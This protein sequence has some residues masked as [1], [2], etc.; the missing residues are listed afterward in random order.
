MVATTVNQMKRV[1]AGFLLLFLLTV[2]PTEAQSQGQLNYSALQKY[3]NELYQVSVF[4]NSETAI[5]VSIPDSLLKA[6]RRQLLNFL[7]SNNNIRHIYYN[8]LVIIL[9]QGGTDP[10]VNQPS[11]VGRRKYQV[12]G[13]LIDAHSGKSINGGSIII[14]EANILINADS[15]GSFEFDLLPGIYS[16]KALGQGTFESNVELVLE[17]DRILNIELFEKTVELD[18]V[19]ISTTVRDVNVINLQPGSLTLEINDIK[20]IPAFLGEIDVSR[21]VISLPG[22]TTVG[23]GATGFNVRGGNIDQNLILLDGMSLFNSSHLLGFFSA[24]NPDLLRDFTLYKGLIPAD[25]GGRISSVLD[26]NQKGANNES[27]GFGASIGPL[28]SK[29]YVNVPIIKNTS[30]LSLGVRGAYPN[31]VLSSFPDESVVSKSKASYYDVTAKY[32]HE[33][34]GG[35]LITLDAYV[36]GDE[37]KLSADTSF[38]Y[39]SLLLGLKYITPVA[40]KWSLNLHGFTSRYQAGIEDRTLNQ[41]A[42]FENGISQISLK[43]DLKYQGDRA[44]HILGVESNYYQFL[45]GEIVPVTADSEVSAQKLPDH[46]AIDISLYGSTEFQLNPKLGF[47]A[48][49]RVTSFHNIGP[50]EFLQFEEGVGKEPETV[51][52]TVQ[53]A[54]GK[55]NHVNTSVE[56]RVS[57]NYRVSPNSSLKAGYSRTFQY[58]HLFSNTVASLPTDLWRPSDPNLEPVSAHLLSLGYF[59]NFRENLFETSIEVFYKDINNVIEF[60]NGTRIL[61]NEELVF[62]TLQGTAQAYGLELL[63]KKTKG[64]FT[65]RLGYTYSRAWSKFQSE[66]EQEN[67]NNG[68]YFPADFDRPHD[69]NIFGNL[70]LGRL[71]NVSANFVYTTGRPI[72]LPQTS[73]RFGGAIGYSGIERNTFRIPDFHRLDLSITLEGSNKKER[74]LQSSWTFSIYNVYGR[75]NVYS[76]FING[77]DGR[78]R[79]LSVLGAPFPSL[80]FNLKLL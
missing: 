34:E 59:R 38:T 72:S 56:P 70:K 51:T 67:L 10:D 14:P 37:F 76:V 30:A 57:F 75:K 26:V 29:L 64:N 74:R 60:T 53:L 43:A 40:E 22:V 69:L 77:E 4:A 79:Q 65:G 41:E 49:I 27:F 6:D 24:F 63:L 1:S 42:D 78:P 35:S 62:N 48:G 52:D 50:D 47:Q 68:E 5:Q 32:D 25:K 80:T 11:S 15:T 9:Y 7:E 39:S 66:I 46:K 3:F 55:L 17:N 45:T 13:Q 61:L 73:F 20:K 23:E 21:A 2:A 44:N 18:E 16:L 8:P 58:I 31:Y 28:N 33:F 12:K 71:W 54:S 36:G 19:V